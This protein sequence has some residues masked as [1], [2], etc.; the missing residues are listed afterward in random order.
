MPTVLVTGANR[1]IGL[2]FARQYA[3][4]GWRVHATARRPEEAGE[5]EVAAGDVQLYKLDVADAAQIAALAQ[6]LAGE[7]V[8]VLINNAGTIGSRAGF[9]DTDVELWLDAFRTNTIA[10]LKMAEHFIEHLERGGQKRIISLTSRMG[11]IA[12]NTGGGYYVYRSSKAGLNAVTKSLAIDL[13]PRGIVA[14]VFHPGWVQ[15]EM[16][17]SGAT[18]S[19]ADSVRAMRAK[20][21]GLRPEDSGSFFNYDGS[22]IPW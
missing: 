2:E 6:R 5:L 16:G 7:A 14:I 15:T 3:A 17:G 22:Y 10:P 13:A 19:P 18:L 20:I 4:E 8:D 11:S 9:G 21:A 12:D 1:G